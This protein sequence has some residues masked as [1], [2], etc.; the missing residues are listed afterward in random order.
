MRT[1][2]SVLSLT[3]ASLVS[4]A[5]GQ[6]IFEDLKIAPVDGGQ[7]DQFGSSVAIDQGVIVVGAHRDDDNG[8]DSGS[9]YLYNA[10][11]GAMIAKLLPADGAAGDLFGS[12]VA[13]RSG[14]AIVGAPMDVHGGIASGSAYL[15]DVNTGTQ[16]AKLIAEDAEAGD[17][18]G[19]SVAI[20]DGVVA[21]GARGEQNGLENST[22][23]AYLFDASTGAQLD[24]L[25][26]DGPGSGFGLSIAMDDGVVAVGKR[27]VFDLENGFTPDAVYLFDVSSGNQ[28]H[29]LIPDNWVW[30]DFFGVAVDIDDGL[31]AVG[32][33]AKSIFFDHSG[34]A[35]VFDA[36]S[37]EQLHYIF[38]S[39]GHDRDH[40]GYSVSID[41]GILAI[42]AE[43]DGDS[44]WVAGS[45]YLFDAQSGDQIDKLLASDGAEFDYLG[46]TVAINGGVVAVGAIGDEDNG[47]DSGS[48][49]L[50]G[51]PSVPCPADLAA[52][53]GSLDFSDVV[54]FLGAFDDGASAADLAPPI[55]QFD[56]SDVAA[57]LA[58]FGAGC[59]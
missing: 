54:A 5:S 49:Y 50:F 30:T 23:S 36:S 33:W 20:A 31:V 34:A 48:V 38:P 17:L 42:G 27:M 43:Q 44:G 40:F 3:A 25:I 15:F 58:A 16:I 10:A 1:L 56:F 46:T 45:A 21:V 37:G 32:A 52:P 29:K 55:G 51:R 41:E 24:K 53:F 57:F 19:S 59:P 39:D 14:I 4:A 2:Q 18:F 7:G 22:G 12:S 28:L 35:Y 13:V 8:I 11:N 9:A 6:P 47:A 26:P